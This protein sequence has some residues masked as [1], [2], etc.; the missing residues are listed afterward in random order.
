MRIVIF[1]ILILSSFLGKSQGLRVDGGANIII[2]NGANLI[3]SG[4][5]N[6]TNNGTANCI[7]GSWVRFTGNAAQVIQ[8]SSTTAFSNVEVNNS[9]VSVQVGRDISVLTTLTMNQGDF[10]LKDYV[11]DFSTTGSLVNETSARRIKSTD[12]GGVDGF[13]TGTITAT[14]NNPSGNVAG[15]GLNITP[16]AALGNT[17]LVRGHERQAGS[18]TFAG[19]WS[20]YRYYEIQPTTYSNTD[21]VFSYFP[22]W[23][24][25]VHTDGTLVAYQRVQYYWGGWGG[26]I[27]WEPL[28]SVNASPNASSTT[29]YNALSANVRV[30]LGSDDTPL[31]VQLISFTGSCLENFNLIEWKTSSEFNNS[32]FILEKSFN[33]SDFFAIANVHGAGNSNQ[34]QSYTFEDFS[35]KE[36]INYYRL[37]QVDFDGN[38]NISNIVAV[39]CEN[40]YDIKIYT[41]NFQDIV[42]DFINA[43]SNNYALSVFDATGKLVLLT[44][45]NI[46]NS[47]EKIILPTSN[48]ASGV[49]FVKTIS[50]NTINSEKISIM[51]N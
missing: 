18:G 47:Y 48:L 38:S 27:Y 44:N 17:V 7:T 9:G 50:D 16:S 6:W 31:P 42:V 14:R 35:E 2:Q 26:P 45:I 32:H 15:L 3:I 5:G 20:I 10:D 13:G 28:T 24:L 39:N 29:V 40:D 22:A 33:G 46:E 25:G 19:N 30:T 8:G 11:V 41:N 43:P 49:Y 34:I 1:L 51:K 21:F 37:T 36:N 4:N 12:G 23:E